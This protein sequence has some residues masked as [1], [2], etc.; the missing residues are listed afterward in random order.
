MAHQSLRRKARDR[1]DA[2]SGAHKVCRVCGKDKPL[3]AYHYNCHSTDYRQ[4]RCV[5][6]DTLRKPVAGGSWDRG[7]VTVK[8]CTLCYGMPWRVLDAACPRCGLP[9]VEE[10]P[11]CLSAWVRRAD[12]RED[13]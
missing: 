10:P 9:H 6:C 11:E 4:S 7:H 13:Y 2:A 8:H 12:P 5:D 3:T 1:I